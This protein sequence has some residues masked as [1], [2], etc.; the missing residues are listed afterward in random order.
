ML[1]KG[2][3]GIGT[4]F[5]KHFTLDITG[6]LASFGRGLR[7]KNF[8]LGEVSVYMFSGSVHH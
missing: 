4:A 7:V 3:S 8:I 2:R 5:F 1:K 6:T